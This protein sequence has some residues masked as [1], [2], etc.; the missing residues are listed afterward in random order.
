MIRPKSWAILTFLTF[1][2][3]ADDEESHTQKNAELETDNEGCVGT[4]TKRRKC[5]KLLRS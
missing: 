2:I 4:W 5:G 1:K 3:K